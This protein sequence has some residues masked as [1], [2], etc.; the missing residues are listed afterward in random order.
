MQFGLV[1]T[2]EENREH[3]IGLLAT[4]SARGWACRC[5]L[6]DRAVR[7][8]TVPV[9]MDTIRS[10]HIRLDVCEHSWDRFGDGA[11]PGDVTLGGQYQDAELVHLSN[12]VLVL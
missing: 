5:F 10:S 12:R 7:L 4:A 9:F 2:S 6:T 1:L 8:L 3:A 11:P